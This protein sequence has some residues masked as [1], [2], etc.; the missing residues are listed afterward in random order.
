M[1]YMRVICHIGHHKTGTT[2]LQAFLSQNFAS[3]LRAGIL[4]PWTES[5]GAAIAIARM[6][7]GDKTERDL[8]PINFREGHNALAFRMLADTLPSWKVPAYHRELPHSRQMLIALRNQ[9]VRLAPATLVLCSE[10]M[11]QFG[12]MAPGSI[13]RLCNE[14]LPKVSDFRLWCTLRRPDEQLVSWHGQSVRFGQ[15]PAA[16]SDPVRGV[17]FDSI[18]FDYRNVIEPWLHQINGATP[19]LRPYRETLATGGS[20]EDFMQHSGLS[21]PGALIAAPRLNISRKPAV[22]SLLRLAN[23]A[24]PRPLSLELGEWLDARS[25]KLTLASTSEVEFFGPEVRAH[26]CDRF[27]PIHRWLAETTGRPTFFTDIEEMALCNPIPEQDA[28]RG[29]LDQLTPAEV[30]KTLAPEIRTFLRHQRD[31]A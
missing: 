25:A 20:V 8:L 14:G 28:L 22:V 16:L 4:Y 10:V 26:L 1:G 6:L 18:H 11:S 24:L 30:D 3:L 23:S 12:K 19:F 7:R 27:R 2:T 31:A 15:S 9:A 13:A 21:A 29:L 5:E 17:S